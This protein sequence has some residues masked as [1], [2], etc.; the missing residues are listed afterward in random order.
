MSLIS[1]ISC[2]K[3]SE[4]YE[5]FRPQNNEHFSKILLIRVLNI[6]VYIV[7]KSCN[8]RACEFVLVLKL[9]VLS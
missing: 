8:L 9:I 2:C 7:A 3:Y 5:F 6:H 1:F 4:K